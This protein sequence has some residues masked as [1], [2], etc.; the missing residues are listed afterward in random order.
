MIKR[1][2]VAAIAVVFFVLQFNLN[3]ASALELNEKTLTIT[4][5][6]A[7]ESVT[8]TSEQATEGQKLFVANCTKCHLQGKTKTNNNVSLGLADLAKAEPPRDNLLALIDYLEHPTSY[9]G[10][11]DLSEFHPNV[12]RPD[13][14]P[15]LRNLTE[16]D[17]YNV[18]AYLLV[19][20]R[21]DERWGGTIY[22]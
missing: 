4:L 9:D 21:L 17:V 20:P 1:L 8:L 14:F 13:I 10:E 5:N 12:S 15:E 22:F 6:D 2:I 18:A 7:R 19:A 16:D 3:G 11:D